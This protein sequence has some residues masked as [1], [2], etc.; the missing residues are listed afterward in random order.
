MAENPSILTARTLI[1]A[2]VAAGVPA[3]A[4]CPGS[5]N[6]PFAYALAQAE[7]DKLLEVGTFSDERSAGFWSIGYMKAQEGDFP[8]AVITTSGTAAAELHPAV[9]EAKH[10]ELPLLVITAD[11]PHHMRGVGA[12]QTTEQEGLFGP[13]VLD[14]AAIPANLGRPEEASAV[15]LRLIRAAISEQGPVHLN[16][17][18]SDPLVPATADSLPAVTATKFVDA[19]Q[20]LPSWE[21]VCDTGLDTIVVAGDGADDAV[22][23][24]A[25]ARGVPIIG[26]PS[27]GACSSPNWVAHGPL[28]LAGHPQ[29]GRVGQV[30]VTGRPT[31]TRPVTALLA[32]TSVRKVVI[33]DRRAYSDIGGNAAVVAPGISSAH[34]SPAPSKKQGEW[35]ESWQTAARTA[36]AAVAELADDHLNL[37]SICRLIWSSQTD[38]HLW[39]AASNAVRGFDLGAAG[40][41][42]SRVFANRGL[43]GIDGSVATA[44]GLASGAKHP[45]RAVVGDMAFAV[46]L[47]TLVQAPGGQID[48]QVV[49]L[50]DAGAGIF[51][52]LEHG[53]AP[54][55]VYERF[56]AVAPR[57]DVAAAASS[58]GW[59]SARVT[60][61]EELERILEEP[62]VG[63]S[64]IDVEMPRPAELIE[65]V[66]SR[67]AE[68]LSSL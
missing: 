28:V 19:K 14:D 39:L 63:L 38:A 64:V 45:V 42:T 36:G 17:A 3:V 6:A 59:K 12:S 20:E 56:F 47:S 32:D 21:D 4:Y 55:D 41:G 65:A 22:V 37:L 49:V 18:F 66:K 31:L 30:V 51:A 29:M 11:R 23:K 15:L 52:S 44:L 40:I 2:L 5:R 62:V 34:Q 67:V 54:Q 35:L 58:A 26:E 33:S 46:D 50:N 8:V 24:A 61:L 48:L 27:S 60:S 7:D 53:N 16:V 57:V 1:G 43:A 9:A 10:Q 25:E 13:S 68:E